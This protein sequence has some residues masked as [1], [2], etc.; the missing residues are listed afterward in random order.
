MGPA[1]VPLQAIFLVLAVCGT[2][3][4]ATAQQMQNYLYS[5]PQSLKNYW[6]TISFGRTQFNET[7]S[8]VRSVRADNDEFI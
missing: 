5:D 1:P 8:M 6:N 7:T 3:S 4:A 2:G